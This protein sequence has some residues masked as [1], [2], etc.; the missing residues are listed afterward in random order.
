[1]NQKWKI[2]DCI[3]SIQEIPNESVDMIFADPPF[4]M[5]KE[6]GILTND[7]R[8]DYFEWCDQWISECFRILKSTGSF[9]HMNLTRNLDNLMPIM[10]KYGIF[11]NLIIW[12]N[13]S[14]WGIKNRFYPKYQPI[15]FY[16]KTDNFKFNTYTQREQ[17][18]KRWGKMT[19][20]MQ[21]QMGD[22]WLDIPFVWAGSIHH[23]EAII[24]PGTNSKVHPAQMPVGL[25][26]RCIEFSTDKD[27]LVCDPFLGSGTTLEACRKTDRNCIGFEISDEWEYLYPLRSLEY[28]PGLSNYI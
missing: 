26:K 9:Y 6:Y 27:D 7:N 28:Q 11:Q 25:V 8:D 5:K 19:G 13:V 10:K 12:R 23:K 16:S 18:F 21:G 24:K 20:K 15:M 3:E 4:N 17:P 1:M 14:S 22:I 2:G